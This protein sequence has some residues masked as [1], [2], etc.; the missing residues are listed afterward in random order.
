MFII[1]CPKLAISANYSRELAVQLYIQVNGGWLNCN[2]K[3]THFFY[4][5]NVI[6]EPLKIVV[7]MWRCFEPMYCVYIHLCSTYLIIRNR[8]ANNTRRNC[9]VEVIFVYWV[10]NPIVLN[11]LMF[12]VVT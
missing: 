3:R 9:K 11:N 8:L 1:H 2:L 12:V 4:N 10:H 7:F 5:K 6:K